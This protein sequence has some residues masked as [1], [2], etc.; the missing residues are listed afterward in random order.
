MIEIEEFFLLAENEDPILTE[1]GKYILG[2]R[3]KK[4]N[5][6]GKPLQIF[7]NDIYFTDPI[8]ILEEE[9]ALL[10]LNVL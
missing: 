5:S 9:E 10:I 8:T 7:P 1:S 6:G 3:I 4:K 2:Q